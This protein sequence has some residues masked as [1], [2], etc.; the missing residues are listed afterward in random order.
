MTQTTNS[1][2]NGSDI[3]GRA[4][5]MSGT[6]LGTGQTTATLDAADTPAM[7][8]P[9]H[10]CICNKITTLGTNQL[11]V[12]RLAFFRELIEGSSLAREHATSLL[13]ATERRCV[14]LQSMTAITDG[15]ANMRDELITGLR[16]IS[17]ILAQK[18]DD[19]AN[20]GADQDAG[21]HRPGAGDL[22]GGT[23]SVVHDAA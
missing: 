13:A 16:E 18:L 9:L 15:D 17:T 12:Y 6:A 2:G 1:V 21:H 7:K 8:P 14:E 4:G 10:Q 5:L 11:D 3:T 22:P 19:I 23:A 20:R